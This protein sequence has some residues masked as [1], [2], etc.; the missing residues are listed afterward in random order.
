MKKA[1]I[2]MMALAFVLAAGSA[3]AATDTSPMNVTATVS[4]V[5]TIESVSDIDFGAYDPTSSTDD[6]AAGDFTFRC[7]KAT[8]YDLYITGTRQMTDGGSETLDFELYSDAGR[9]TAWPSASPGITGTAASNAQDTRDVYGR[10]TALQDAGV[11]S[12]SAVVTI[13]VEY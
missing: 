10:I 11:G 2:L 6:D 5:C 1:L 12:Y 9:T 8:D 4:A 13:T 7:V 3:Y